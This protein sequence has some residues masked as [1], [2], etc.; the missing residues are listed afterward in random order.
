MIAIVLDRGVSGN[1]IDLLTDS[2][3]YAVKKVGRVR[4]LEFEVLREGWK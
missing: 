3:D 4:N 1:V 2:K